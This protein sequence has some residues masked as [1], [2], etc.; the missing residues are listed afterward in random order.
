MS[1]P[2][3]HHYVPQFYLRR[4]SDDGRSIRLLHKPSDRIIERASIKG[5]C[6]IDNFHGWHELAE[7]SI[8]TIEG[9]CAT[10]IDRVVS[11]GI[12]PDRS[13][14][15]YGHLLLFVALQSMRTQQSADV[16]NALVDRFAK[17]MM[18][19]RP[20]FEK[21]DLSKFRVEE[22]YPV[23]L[24]AHQIL[25][26]LEMSL[27][28]TSSDRGF[29]TSDN[30]VVLYNSGRADVWW[31]GVTGLD[32]EGL[33]LF[34]PLNRNTC[35]YM[36]DPVSYSPPSNAGNRTLGLLDVLKLNALTILNSRTNVYGR[37]VRDLILAKEI[38]QLTKP[39]EDFARIAFTET[40]S[41]D[42]GDGKTASLIANYRLHAPLDVEF[43]FARRR[44]R[45]A[46]FGIRSDRS[47]AARRKAIGKRPG[48]RTLRVATSTI[49]SPRPLIKDAEF[50]RLRRSLERQSSTKFRANRPNQ[51]VTE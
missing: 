22:K 27:L 43:R 5:Q 20:E 12:I 19:G 7:R 45:Q 21:I 18:Q 24:E 2:R 26:T 42:D 14:T 16:S 36:F 47:A 35:L 15:D 13:S 51:P 30:P 6:A 33:Q 4:F 48:S 1:N 37:S 40:E 25:A 32:C 34:L 39:Y 3:S 49:E 8:A 9:A 11:Q 17:L 50:E 41:Y 46:D 23:A 10:T 31:E 28:T 38:R 44:A 29:L